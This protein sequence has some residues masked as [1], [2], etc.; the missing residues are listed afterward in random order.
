MTEHKVVIPDWELKKK[1]VHVI[2]EPGYL[3]QKC[4][5]TFEIL[6]ASRNDLNGGNRVSEF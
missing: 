2:F 1:S 5:L 6:T 3:S 4:L